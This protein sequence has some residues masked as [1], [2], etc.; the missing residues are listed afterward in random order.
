MPMLRALIRSLACLILITA[1][2]QA[3][4]EGPRAVLELFTSQ[5]CSSCPP[6][7][8]LFATMATDPELI[9]LSLPVD[10]WDRLGWK[11]TFA[12]PA[13][14]ARQKAYA[15][16]RGDARVYTPQAVI[17]GAKHAVGSQR[18][19]NRLHGQKPN[20]HHKASAHRGAPGMRGRV[21]TCNLRARGRVP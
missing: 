17:N 4:A 20:S 18:A 7:D 5:G 2:T 1:G 6:A 10:Y 14:T 3:H 8:E 12:N 11:D 16:D 13:F 19:A 15:A 9:T 21:L